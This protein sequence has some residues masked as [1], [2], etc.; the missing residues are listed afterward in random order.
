V[1]LPECLATQGQLST[2]PDANARSAGLLSC[3][4]RS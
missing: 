2:E 3:S 1:L 4:T